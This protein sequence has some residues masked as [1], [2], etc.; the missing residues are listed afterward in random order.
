MIVSHSKIPLSTFLLRFYNQLSIRRDC[1]ECE[2][3]INEVTND[4]LFLFSHDRTMQDIVYK[5]VPGLQEGKCIVFSM[6]PQRD[7]ANDGETLIVL[8]GEEIYLLVKHSWCHC[9]V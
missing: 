8:T 1:F 9:W 4:F 5:L 3:Q 6:H 2:T 7:Q